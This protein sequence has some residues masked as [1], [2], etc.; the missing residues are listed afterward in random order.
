MLGG[1]LAESTLRPSADL[2]APGLPETGS[3][4]A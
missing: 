4:A 2:Q 3:T 1:I